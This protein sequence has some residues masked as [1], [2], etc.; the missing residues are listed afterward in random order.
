MFISQQSKQC[1]EQLKNPGQEGFEGRVKNPCFPTHL[2]TIYAD[3]YNLLPLTTVSERK[4]QKT[5]EP[6][7]S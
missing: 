7:P 2:Y 5:L 1:S 3:N 4:Q 6:S